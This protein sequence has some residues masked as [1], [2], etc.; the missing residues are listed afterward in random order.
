[1]IFRTP[2]CGVM[3]THLS[4]DVKKCTNC[5]ICQVWCSF[6]KVGA[7]GPAYARIRPYSLESEGIT[8][9]HVCHHC[10]KALCMDACPSKAL[11]RSRETG[12]VLIDD[13]VCTGCRSC[14]AACPFGAVFLDP[15][16]K[17]IK[18]D[19]CKGLPAPVCQA[20]CP[21]GVIS[22]TKSAFTEV[23]KGSP[24]PKR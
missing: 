7:V 8:V 12:A 10:D 4:I 9:P 19:L 17:V 18:C 14:I 6:T 22:W 5:K 16:G 23:K 11:H 2:V 1:M 24:R 21:K 20:R 3:H 13:D 15:D